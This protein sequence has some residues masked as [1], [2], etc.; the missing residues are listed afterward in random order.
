MAPGRRAPPRDVARRTD[1]CR[2]F[3]P[4]WR[5]DATTID[6]SVALAAALV[7]ISG[8]SGAGG[9][10]GASGEQRAGRQRPADGLEQLELPAHD[11]T[12]ANI[13]AQANALMS[14]GLS[15]AGYLYVNLDDF[16]YQCPGSQGP[17]VDANGRWVT[18]TTQVPAERPTTAS[19]SSPT[20]CTAWA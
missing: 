7:I 13:E 10:A 11:P 19:R 2:A 8:R 9:A 3:L 1:A 17:N 16:W 15:A 5:T 4:G 6:E 14:S 12:A 18:D 20:T